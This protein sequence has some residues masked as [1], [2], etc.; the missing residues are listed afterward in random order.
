MRNTNSILNYR[1]T[2]AKRPALRSTRGAAVAAWKTSTASTLYHQENTWHSSHGGSEE[3]HQTLPC[4]HGR[5]SQFLR[6]ACSQ[7]MCRGWAPQHTTGPS[8]SAR[9]DTPTWLG[10][11]NPYS[12]STPGWTS[13]APPRAELLVHTASFL[14]GIMDGKTRTQS[15]GVSQG[16]TCSGC[17]LVSSHMSWQNCTNFENWAH[18]SLSHRHQIPP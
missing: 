3:S 11:F 17:T 14:S 9:I 18:R 6:S 12:K 16:Y 5:S 8:K 15:S 1:D 13:S 7:W 2:R 10:T 4:K